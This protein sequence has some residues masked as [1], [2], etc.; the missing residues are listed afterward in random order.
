M[1]KKA[2]GTYTKVSSTTTAKKKKMVQATQSIKKRRSRNLQQL[3][4]VLESAFGDSIE[5]ITADKK[6][7]GLLIKFTRP[8][9]VVEPEFLQK[10]KEILK[11]FD[12]DYKRTRLTNQFLMNESYAYIYIYEPKR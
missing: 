8:Q 5:R 1:S 9:I 10:F 7:N 3:Q 2:K 12:I 6:I 4:V 11:H